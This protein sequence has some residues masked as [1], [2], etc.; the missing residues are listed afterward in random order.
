MKARIRQLLSTLQG[1]RPPSVQTAAVASIAAIVVSVVLL[2]TR[3]ALFALLG[4][5]AS[6]AV[7]GG[8][9][10]RR[11]LVSGFL[12]LGLMTIIVS[13]GGWRGRP[14][15]ED[16]PPVGPGQSGGQPPATLPP[17]THLLV[18]R[19][20]DVSRILALIDT[21]RVVAVVGRRAV[22]TSTLAMH[23]ADRIAERF[24][25]GQIYLDF[26]SIALGRPLSE[27]RALRRVLHALGLA[28]PQ[29]DRKDALDAAADALHA[30]LANRRMLFL[31]DNVDQ[32]Q[33]VRRLLP[34]GTGCRFLLAG[35]VDLERL[36][37]VHVYDLSEI[38]ED[39]AVEFL[40]L[41]GDPE[42]VSRDRR[43]AVELVNRCGRQPL[44]IRLLGQLLRD[45]K[46]PPRRVLEAMEGGLLAT[47]STRGSE[48][49]AALRPVWDACDVTYQDL[50]AAH[51]RLFRLLILVPTAEI[52]INAVA[53]VAGVPSNRAAR[54]LAELARRGLVESTRPGHYRIRQMLAASGHFYLEQEDSPRHL[55]RA[56]LRLAR[57]YARLAMGYAEPLLPGMRRTGPD[58]VRATAAARAW[59]QQE[60]ELLFSLVTSPH[61][62]LPA[63]RR[64]EARNQPVASERWLWRLAIALC[65]WYAIEG[66]LGDWY[67]V[68][69][70]VLKLPLARINPATAS[71]AHNELGVI[72]RLRGEPLEAWKELQLAAQKCRKFRSLGL[73]QILTNLGMTLAD[74]GQFDGALRNLEQGLELRARTD[75]YGQAISALALGVTYFCA[76]ELEAARRH[77]IRA[78]NAFDVL[79][80][81]RGLA[82]ALNAIGVVLWAQDDRLGGTEHWELARCHY[83]ELGDQAG[84]AGVL[85]NIAAGT[86]IAHPDR[87]AR[88]RD[89]LTESQR[90]RAGQ[91]ETRTTGLSHLY[92]GDA[93]ALCDAPGEAQRHWQEAARILGPTGGAEAAE[94][95]LRSAGTISA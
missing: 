94:E 81:L 67:G 10:W 34:G 49:S 61:L 77:L 37:G 7:T 52:G 68:C 44:A 74:Q 69:E 5:V 27:D 51:R 45:R 48:Q 13:V 95:R 21:E 84:L 40:S 80:D 9:V 73:S 2:L 11:A 24:P 29:P 78:A 16:P 12:V 60:H 59:F 54:L 79:G 43:S 42:L 4:N 89:L 55:D 72:R 38:G 19:D 8:P 3:E 64:K 57:H 25:D 75:R 76:G 85:V 91:P 88:A 46:W 53:A 20:D 65:T 83:V 30:W 35:S 58:R 71:W 92:L 31:L 39:A 28:E 26:R 1:F 32:P 66:R 50:S 18:G 56:R 70:A 41:V 82:A 47:A 33:Q 17:V 23:I 15:S 63:R 6:N 87:A 14:R 62:V 22:G 86:L 36:A 93:L 90:L